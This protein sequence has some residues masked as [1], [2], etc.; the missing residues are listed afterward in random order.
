MSAAFDEDAL[1]FDR[2]VGLLVK[3]YASRAEDPGFESRMRL[4]FSR[5]KS[6]QWLQNWHLKWLP[7]QA[8]GVMGSSQG[9]V[10]QVSVYCG[11]VR[12]KVGSATSISVWQHVTL[13]EIH[14]HIAK[15]VKGKGKSRVMT[16]L[17]GR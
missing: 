17:N 11:W 6:Y 1:P 2:L 3:A 9:L 16:A 7:C 10:G 8:P 4:D 5:V 14:L 15:D 13:S 12:W